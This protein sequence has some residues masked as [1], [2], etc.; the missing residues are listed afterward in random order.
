MIAKLLEPHDSLEFSAY[1]FFC[2]DKY[3][4]LSGTACVHQEV[5][6]DWCIN[7]APLIMRTESLIDGIWQ[8]K[9]NVRF[10]LGQIIREG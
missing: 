10:G 2:V 5:I 1:F 9:A 6:S 8:R 4:I 3:I 7:I